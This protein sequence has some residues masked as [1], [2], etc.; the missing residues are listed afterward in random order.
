MSAPILAAGCSGIVVAGSTGEAALLEEDERLALLTAAREIV[1]RDRWLIAGI[2][3][4]STRQTIRRS[5]DAARIG[6]DAV[7]VVGP[8]YYPES[9]TAEALVDHYRAVADANGPPVVLYSIPKYMHYAIPAPVVQTLAGHPRIIGI[10]D[11]GGDPTLLAGYLAAQSP[12]FAVLTGHGG[13][14]AQALASGVRGGVLGVALLVPALVET[15]WAAALAGRTEEARAAQERLMPVARDIV[16]ALGVPG[17]KAGLDAVG[18][19]GG[20]V[21]PPLEALTVAN[22]EHVRRVLHAALAAPAAAVA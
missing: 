22:Q 20:P 4:E 11:S 9:R 14:L 15:L 17:V 5:V 3:A 1:P 21:R 2:G 19:V 16:G 18:L 13:T 7:M 10:K 8:H 12:T 6:V